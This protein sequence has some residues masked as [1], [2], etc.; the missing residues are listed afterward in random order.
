MQLGMTSAQVVDALR[1][2]PRTTWI[3][4]L[5]ARQAAWSG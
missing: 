4:K 3:A 5:A 2:T 1:D